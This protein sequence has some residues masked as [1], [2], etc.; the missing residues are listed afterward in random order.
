MKIS[1]DLRR[2]ESSSPFSRS[3]TIRER[4]HHQ[5]MY[6]ETIVFFFQGCNSGQGHEDEAL[7]PQHGA[8]PRCNWET[9]HR[10]RPV[11]LTMLVC[12]EPLI[13]YSG[14]FYGRVMVTIKER[15]NPA[16][17]HRHSTT[18]ITSAITINK[19]RQYTY[20]LFPFSTTTIFIFKL[21][22]NFSHKEKNV[23]FFCNQSFS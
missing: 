19:P 18:P 15:S 1:H 6:R 3:P 5:M 7:M 14:T 16:P 11:Q 20:T 12:V 22:S 10:G 21:G 8:T 4:G 2:M 23:Y 9:E 17:N 13:L